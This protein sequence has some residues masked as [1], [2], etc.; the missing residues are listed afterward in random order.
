[1][2]DASGLPAVAKLRLVICTRTPRRARRPGWA[3][4]TAIGDD[5]WLDAARGKR[6]PS[7]RR[8]NS[9]ALY[10]PILRQSQDSG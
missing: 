8:R 4:L 1:M 5:G 2:F 9:T 10:A 6:A 3:A 7:G